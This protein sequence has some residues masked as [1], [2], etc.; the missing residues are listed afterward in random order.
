VDGAVA[1]ITA[2]MSKSA[3]LGRIWGGDGPDGWASS[4][5]DGGVVMGGKSARA[6]RWAAAL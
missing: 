3:R 6:W 1:G 2:A 4:V 5:S